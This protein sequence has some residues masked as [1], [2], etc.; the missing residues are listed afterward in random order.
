MK[1][2]SLSFNN[3]SFLRVASTL[4][5]IQIRLSNVDYSKYKD[6]EKMSQKLLFTMILIE[7]AQKKYVSEFQVFSFLSSWS[8]IQLSIKYLKL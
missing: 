4:N 8:Y 7:T 6:I 3:T 2:I 5:L 1:N